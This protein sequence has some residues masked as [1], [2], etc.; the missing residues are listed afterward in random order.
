LQ[1]PKRP[2]P[3]TLLIGGAPLVEPLYLQAKERGLHL[4]LTYA[5]TE[6]SSTVLLT[7]HPVWRGAA[8]LLG[9][10]LEGRELKI[11]DNELFVRGRS[12]FAGYGRIPSPPSDW[13]ATGDTAIFDPQ[14]GFAITG[15]K[16]FQFF[17]GGENIQPEEIEAVLLSHPLVEQAIVVPQPDPEFGARPAA[18]VRTA[19]SL[20]ELMAFAKCMLPT[21]KVPVSFF[22]L[23]EQESLKPNRKALS[24]K[25]F[26]LTDTL[27]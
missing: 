23:P 3:T 14:L 6:M 17:S 9:H 22:P 25:I 18:F 8:P 24:R 21:Y 1:E 16:D 7:F 2:C 15:R 5:L 11:E 19:A 4:C 12:L 27:K 26:N 10:P 13:F 20:E